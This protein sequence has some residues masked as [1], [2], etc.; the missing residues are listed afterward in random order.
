MTDHDFSSN[1]DR[2]PPQN[3][4]AEEAILGGILL[5]PEAYDR[6]ADKLQPEMFCISAHR[7]IYQ[8]CRALAQKDKPTDLLSVINWLADYNLLAR[9]GGRNKLTS[10]LDRTVSA[11]NIDALADLV[12]DKYRRRQL[13]KAG[14]EIVHLGYETETDLQQVLERSESKLLEVCGNVFGETEP[15]ALADIMVNAF[16]RIEERHQARL[17]DGK[18]G[19]P[20]GFYDLDVMLNGGFKRGKLITVAARPGCGKSSFLGNVAV[21]MATLYNFPSVIFSLE[22]DKEEW[23][24]RFLSQDANIESSYLQTGRIGNHQWEPI[25]RS[26]GRLSELPIFIDDDPCLTVS[27]VRAKVKRLIAK[28]GQLGMVGIDYLG[29]ME[30][31]DMNSANLAFAIGKATRAL[32]QLAR[33]CSV[34]VVLLSQLNRAVE[35]RQNKRPMASDLR[36]S[37]RI[38]EDSDIVIMLY[39]DELYDQNSPDRG[40]AEVSIVKHRGGAVGTVRMLFDAQF[41]Q[42]KN[43]ASGHNNPPNPPRLRAL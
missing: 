34:P 19:Y 27:A 9:I 3:I 42:F 24:D 21:N 2:L 41:T 33:E 43:F 26:I 11:V 14:N 31:I 15:T 6:I 7:D 20:T 13:I 32:K 36:D 25:S 18:C 8:A 28:H 40:I 12:A 38:E 39:R 35:G 16:Q 10:L 1:I 29:L 23:G 5:D 17:E 22:M 37:G 4:E 30:G